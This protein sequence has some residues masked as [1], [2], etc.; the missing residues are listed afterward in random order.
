MRNRFVQYCRNNL[1][2]D[3]NGYEYYPSLALCALDASFSART[4][5]QSV[6]NVLDRF[7]Q[8]ANHNGVQLRFEHQPECYPAIAQITVSEIIHLLGG[9]DAESLADI[10][11]NHSK[12]ARRL[13]AG[14][15]LDLLNVFHGFRI[16]TYQDFQEQF[17]NQDIADAILELRGVGSATFSYLYLLAGNPN[18]VKVDVCIRR[19]STEATGVNNLTDLQIRELFIYAAGIISQE[20]H[21][22]TAAHLDHI[23]WNYQRGQ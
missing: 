23:A 7:C 8:W 22:L 15:F 10:V 11:N 3:V 12:V 13:K 5:Y 2:F 19:F 21:G 1:T 18:D 9:Q 14:L 20:H 4:T 6:I 17:N 16:E